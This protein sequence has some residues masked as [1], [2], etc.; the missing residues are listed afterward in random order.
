[1]VRFYIDFDSTLFD[2]DKLKKELN[3]QIAERLSEIKDLEKDFVID[4]IQQLF[5]TKQAYSY[6][7]LCDILEGKYSLEN[8]ELKNLLKKIL[9]DGEKFVFEDVLEFFKRL[10]QKQCEI[11]ILTYTL[12]DEGFEYQMLKVLGSK[13]A[14]F[15]DN[16][17]IC[18]KPKGELGLDYE[19]GY[20]LDDNPTQ[21]LSLFKS[22]VSEDRLFRIKRKGTGYSELKISEFQPR[23]FMDFNAIEI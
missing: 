4:E 1:M 14:D 6:F 10:S 8:G 21:L 15:V 17:I 16:I 12:K 7:K 13:L 9:S 3:I 20:F 5:L 11:N 23:E 22:G 19:H 18:T 2:T